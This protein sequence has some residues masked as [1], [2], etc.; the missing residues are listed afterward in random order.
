MENVYL[1]VA[2]DIQLLVIQV[3]THP[4]LS[5][6]AHTC[7]LQGCHP[8]DTYIS[9]FPVTVSRHQE[10]ML[11]QNISH[12]DKCHQVQFIYKCQFV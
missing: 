11:L 1:S 7:H 6:H 5:P 10:V 4:H 9:M 3:T 12:F 8:S 2:S